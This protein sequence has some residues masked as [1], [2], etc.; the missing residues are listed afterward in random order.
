LARRER[1]LVCSRNRTMDGRTGMPFSLA[2]TPESVEELV[3]ENAFLRARLNLSDEQRVTQGVLREQLQRF[4]QRV[5][6]EE[7]ASQEVLQDSAQR[8][9]ENAEEEDSPSASPTNT[10]KRSAQSSSLSLTHAVSVVLRHMQMGKQQAEEALEKLQRET[11]APLHAQVEA[12]EAEKKRLQIRIADLEMSMANT[13]APPLVAELKQLRESEALLRRQLQETQE[14][15]TATIGTF[16][17]SAEDGLVAAGQVPGLVGKVEALKEELCMSHNVQAAQRVVLEELERRHLIDREIDDVFHTA[18]T[19]MLK[20]RVAHLEAEVRAAVAREAAVVAER[21]TKDAQL[22]AA[23]NAMKDLIQ[24][25]S[26]EQQALAQKRQRAEQDA[27]SNP[28]S[29]RG[30]LTKFWYEGRDQI[31]EL[32]R[33][34]RTL[35]TTQD[36]LRVSQGRVAQLE[37][38]KAVLADNLAAL[39]TEVDRRREE[40]R[41]LR[42]HCAGLEA[43]RDRLLASVA[44]TLEPVMSEQELR[45]CCTTI[46]EAATRVAAT[47][48]TVVADPHAIEEALRR[49]QKLKTEVAQ[50]QRQ[51]DQLQRFLQLREDRVCALLEQEALF[52]SEQQQR[53]SSAHGSPPLDS[54]EGRQPSSS[55]AAGAAAG[56]VFSLPQF[57]ESIRQ[58]ANDVFLL[59]ETS[60]ARG[61]GSGTGPKRTIVKGAASGSNEATSLGDSS[62][63]PHRQS[64]VALQQQFQ[65]SQ[66]RLLASHR[67]LLETR[68]EILHLQAELK[69][70][71][72][73]HAAA[74][75]S[76][77]EARRAVE[78]AN[79]A[80]THRTTTLTNELQ[81]MHQHYNA[82]VAMVRTTLDGLCSTLQLFHQLEQHTEKLREMVQAER[83][84]M[85]DLLRREASSWGA[86]QGG[87]R[88]AQDAQHS[89]AAEQI[90]AALRQ[91]ETYIAEAIHQT[92]LQASQDQTSYIGQLVRAIQEQEERV[93][94]AKAA[95][96]ASAQA[97]ASSLVER[98]G[99]AQQQ[100]ESTWKAKYQALEAERTQSVMQQHASVVLQRALEQAL[101]P[102]TTSG[103]NSG[104]SSTADDAAPMPVE[105]EE[106]VGN[107]SGTLQAIRSFITHAR[108]R[109]EQQ[110]QEE[111]Q[112]QQQQQQLQQQ[113][114]VV[115]VP[116]PPLSSAAVA[117]PASAATAS[118]NSPL[119]PAFPTPSLV[120][121]VAAPPAE[122]AVAPVAFTAEVDA[123]TGAQLGPANSETPNENEEV[124][125]GLQAMASEAAPTH[126]AAPAN[127]ERQ[128]PLFA[129]TP[130]P[131]GSEVKAEPGVITGPSPSAEAMN[132]EGHSS[133]SPSAA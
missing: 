65:Q 126:E 78:A 34:V 60:A 48:A 124:K 86:A 7:R 106:S 57:L 19:N 36:D 13:P 108:Q 81:E 15:A 44:M 96:E 131:T 72:S 114:A 112:R 38:R 77:E 101:A 88:N 117:A 87:E 94:A 105:V 4:F 26:E 90:S 97:Q 89:A 46:R 42:A 68:N 10:A 110:Q 70:N 58:G 107:M 21:D 69:S 109:Q 53:R 37:Q 120:S 95:F 47:S 127:E 62:V 99:A 92:T 91:M 64:F 118:V 130:H 20:E 84:D 129:P 85:S 30:E 113:Q 104:T 51:K 111:L 102:S 52:L 41:A 119:T 103:N 22:I 80:L 6:E 115:P 83:R 49:S 82:S 50:L 122:P 24:Q 63:A 3:R 45:A 18:E 17:K 71:S 79:A 98:I 27:S 133:A 1:V 9:E 5:A 31:R 8:N 14:A 132:E 93:K 11:V 35:Q 73:E 76:Q 43:E 2:H 100:W 75:Q 74:L 12:A 54:E 23:Q 29:I 55:D 61:V 40:E 28:S 25:H 56:V 33:Q 128:E 121:G 59:N 32:E 116:P 66:E 16:R 67:E 123:D 125:R 39:A